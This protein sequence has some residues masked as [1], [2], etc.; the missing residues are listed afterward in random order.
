MCELSLL[1]KTLDYLPH[2]SS[3]QTC[4][5]VSDCVARFC[6]VDGAS[7]AGLGSHTAL[8]ITGITS[9]AFGLISRSNLSRHVVVCCDETPKHAEQPGVSP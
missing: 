7:R 9:V 8:G 1:T 3:F 6:S 2:L 5:D 4:F